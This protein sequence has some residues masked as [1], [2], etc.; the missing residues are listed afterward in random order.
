[1]DGE[2]VAFAHEERFNR[3]KS[4]TVFPENAIRFCLK[5]AGISPKQLDAVSFFW[6][7]WAGF[8]RRTGYALANFHRSLRPT[9]GHPAQSLEPI[10]NAEETFRQ[11]FQYTGEFHFVKHPLA[12]AAH[13]AYR[14]PFETAAVLVVDD[15][16][17]VVTTWLGKLTGEGRLQK[18]KE[19][20][21]PHSLGL[22]WNTVTDYLGFR[23]RDDEENVVGMSVRTDECLV[24]MFKELIE[25]RGEGE[26]G[27]SLPYFRFHQSPGNW[28]SKRFIETFGP[29]RSRDEK[30]TLRHR[31]IARATQ[32]TTQEILRRMVTDLVQMANSRNLAYT[33]PMAQNSSANG[34]LIGSGIID[35]LFTPATPNDAGAAEGAALYVH[36]MLYRNRRKTPVQ[37]S[38]YLGPE[39]DDENIE[40]TLKQSGLLFHRCEDI[41]FETAR[42]LAAGKIVGWFQGRLEGAHDGLGNRSI[43]ADPR[44][45]RMKRH[46]NQ[47]VKHFEWYRPFAASVLAERADELFVTGGHESPYMLLTFPIQPAWWGRI[48]AVE[49]ID[50][51]ARVQTV[52]SDQNPRFYDLI[53]RFGQLTQVPALLNTNFN[54]KGYPMVASPKHAVECFKSTGIDVLAIGDFICEKR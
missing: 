10:R 13:A 3:E 48:P 45:E 26:F 20:Y 37:Q 34:D 30:L 22:V 32:A 16:G 7:P 43:L 31:A 8:F 9:F 17:E 29:A 52:R 36:H 23:Q 28:A 54:L 50:C 5:Q 24:E 18:I 1:M 51:T 6:D 39:Y 42:L 21:F 4:T 38:V 27:L 15:S 19:V 53:V 11:I 44:T 41:A 47:V 46:L 35:H 12:H 49:Q 40:H 2:T 25:Y 14:S 33:G